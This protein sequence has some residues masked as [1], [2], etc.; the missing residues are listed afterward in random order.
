MSSSRKVFIIAALLPLVL[1]HV[2]TLV[3]QPAAYWANF[4]LAD[5]G[6]PAKFLLEQ[7]PAWFVLWG[8]FYAAVAA[9]LL[10]KLPKNFALPLG[11]LIYTGH[12]WG[13]S[14]WIPRLLYMVG[15]NLNYYW[16]VTIFYFAVLSI[17]L[18]F[19]ISV[20]LKHEIKTE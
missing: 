3:G 17:A 20:W 5:E 16:Y 9:I 11:L 8:V 10:A 2:V 19:G 7:H 1:D 14:S 4:T 6:S 15:F 18:A 13:S 12:A